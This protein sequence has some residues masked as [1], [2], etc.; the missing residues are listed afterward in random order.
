MVVLY[1]LLLNFDENL[2]ISS[3]HLAEQLYLIFWTRFTYYQ[4]PKIR[5]KDT[6]QKKKNFRK[7]VSLQTNS[8]TPRAFTQL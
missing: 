6:K 8:R 7:L 5:S 3:F 1:E 2:Y 4:S